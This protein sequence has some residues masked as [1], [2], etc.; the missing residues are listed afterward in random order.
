MSKILSL[1]FF[2]CPTDA[3][4]CW[5]GAV[6][7]ASLYTFFLLTGSAP[8]G[9]I[10]N[11]EYVWG[12]RRHTPSAVFGLFLSPTTKLFQTTPCC[13]PHTGKIAPPYSA[14]QTSCARLS[15]V[16]RWWSRF[17][18]RLVPTR[19]FSNRC[20]ISCLFWFGIN[21]CKEKK[22]TPIIQNLYDTCKAIGLV[23]TQFEFSQLCGRN[24][25]WFSANKTRDLP[26]STAAAYTL[27]V[28][29]KQ[30]ARDQ[31]PARLRPHANALSG[32]LMAMINERASK[33][34][35]SQ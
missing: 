20:Q 8:F 34:R 18:L 17:P 7:I 3:T 2:A 27:S 33:Q 13:C 26:I 5:E 23:R 19:L 31:L 4:H 15:T 9:P 10:T 30:A 6:T 1:S 14:Y 12:Y 28:R 35:E 11:A 29:L 16:S 22:H 32:L 24:T 21:I 25:T